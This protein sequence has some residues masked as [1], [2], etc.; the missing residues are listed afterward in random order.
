M[1]GDMRYWTRRKGVAARLAADAVEAINDAS[2]DSL[3][4][5]V[6]EFVRLLQLA[7]ETE[8]KSARRSGYVNAGKLV[9]MDDLAKALAEHVQMNLSGLTHDRMDVMADIEAT[10]ATYAESREAVRLLNGG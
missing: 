3:A 5:W 8:A 4:L 2:G 10:R 9:F 6:D 1:L 7:Y